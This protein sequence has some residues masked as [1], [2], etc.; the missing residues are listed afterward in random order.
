MKCAEGSPEAPEHGGSGGGKPRMSRVEQ[1]LVAEE[2]RRA[3]GGAPGRPGGGAAARLSGRS[4]VDGREERAAAARSSGRRAASRQGLGLS[5][6][7]GLLFLTTD[8]WAASTCR[9]KNIARAMAKLSV[10]TVLLITAVPACMHTCALL[11]GVE[12]GR[13]ALESK[14]DSASLV[15][16]VG[17]YSTQE[18]ADIKGDT[19]AGGDERLVHIDSKDVH[20]VMENPHPW[21]SIQPNKHHHRHPCSCSSSRFH[22]NRKET[23]TLEAPLDSTISRHATPRV[24]TW[25]Y[26]DGRMDASKRHD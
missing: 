22:E 24:D 11:V 15:R 7:L 6:F 21:R 4:C 13:A 3:N 10:A 18:I 12:L 16:G 19:V 17:E 2:G 25:S 8:P 20:F 9:K 23:T 5:T 14:P 1:A 26:M